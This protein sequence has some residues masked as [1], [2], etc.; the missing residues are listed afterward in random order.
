MG[1]P[2]RVAGFIR[3]SVSVGSIE[4]SIKMGTE[5]EGAEARC[6]VVSVG[7]RLAPEHPFPAAVDDCWEAL[8]WL[9]GTGKDELGIN[10]SRIAIGGISAYAYFP[11][12]QTPTN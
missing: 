12:Y 6:V 11:S 10:V 2:S 1:L 3:E 8:L 9:R 4:Q 5:I 7:Y